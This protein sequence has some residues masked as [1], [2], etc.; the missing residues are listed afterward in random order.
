MSDI[1]DISYERLINKSL[2]T[3][4][5]SVHE[6][7]LFVILNRPSARNALSLDMRRSFARLMDEAE[8]DNTVDAVVISGAHGVFSAGADIKEVLSGPARVFR[9]H[10]GEVAKS[11]SKPTIAAVD[12]ACVTGALELALSCDFVIASERSYFADTHAK[13]GLFPGWG[14]NALLA[15]AIGV[16]RARQMSLTGEFIDASTALT[17]GLVNELTKPEDLLNRAF[18]ICRQIGAAN[19]ESVRMQRE[20]YAR[21]D[22][23]PFDVAIAT[24]NAF[25]HRWRAIINA[26]G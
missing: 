26:G 24:E 17:W 2:E 23:A 15:S 22:G 18:G 9:P 21:H 13:A 16:R 5:T 6:R 19:Q 3:I 7:V 25:A 4:V 8:S 20:L 12:G 11:C 10:P 1:A 14:Q